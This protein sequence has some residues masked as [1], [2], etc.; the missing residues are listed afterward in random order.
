MNLDKWP[1][2]KLELMQ[3]LT[4]TLANSYWEATLPSNY[5]KPGPN[6]SSF[7]VKRFLDDKY[8]HR[9]WVD[10]DMKYDPVTMY[11]QK[12]SKFDRW[13]KRKMA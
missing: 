9:K 5:V 1:D 10:P 13:V 8:V 7:E 3:A 12:R 11:E 6:A 4:N 2:G